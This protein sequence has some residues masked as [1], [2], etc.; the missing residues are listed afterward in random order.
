[1]ESPAPGSARLCPA[2]DDH[3]ASIAPLNVGAR[4]QN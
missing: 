2:K 4:P 3:I 1:M